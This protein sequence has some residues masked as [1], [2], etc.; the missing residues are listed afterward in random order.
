MKKYILLLL[1]LALALALPVGCKK[2]EPQP[3]PV[4][5]QEQ[6]AEKPPAKVEKEVLLFYPDKDNNFL[7]PEFRKIIVEETAAPQEMAEM[8]IKELVKGTSNNMLKSVISDDT[9]I[10]SLKLHGSTATIDFSK[11][12]L[13]GAYSG[14]EKLLQVFSVVNTLSEL[15]IE[16]VFILIEGEPVTDHYTSLEADMPFIRNDELI[17]SK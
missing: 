14:R 5:Q 8:V 15:G 17:P 16:E 12:F 10:L 11:D 6:P 7:L 3:D 13:N 4:P 9:E 2:D 1:V